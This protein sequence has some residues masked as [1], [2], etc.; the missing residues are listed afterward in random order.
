MKKCNI[1]QHYPLRIPFYKVI[2][3][4]LIHLSYMMILLSV[5]TMLS[6]PISVGNHRIMGDEWINKH[7]DQTI[8]VKQLKVVDQKKYGGRASCGYHALSNA[9]H[10]MEA[11]EDN[12]YE[13]HKNLYDTKK[14]VAQFGK[15]GIWRYAVR[16][17]RAAMGE[18][19]DGDWVEMEEIREIIDTKY[20]GK[21]SI[22]ADP[23]EIS[24]SGESHPYYNIND[25]KAN[26]HTNN[27]V[28]AFILGSMSNGISSTSKWSK[29]DYLNSGHW[30]SA[31]LHIID[32]K[33]CEL[34][35]MDSLG[36][37]EQHTHPAVQQLLR[38][39]FGE[40][41]QIISVAE[42]FDSSKGVDKNKENEKDHNQ[43]HR[44]SYTAILKK[45]LFCV[46]GAIGMYFVAS[47]FLPE[48]S[49]REEY[50]MH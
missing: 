37:K 32:E 40:V 4:I 8:Y 29:K 19:D 35:I 18:W 15:E 21:I 1:L 42:E 10:I 46:V 36:K 16:C 33:T 39:L 50:E 12:T 5:S 22:Y 26:A 14:I 3:T 24:N 48:E 41:T 31:V 44:I 47:S 6:S 27:Y 38:E 17:V 49:D 20:N 7:G 30:I 25:V 34:F 43:S 23:N 9:E 28:H 13:L 2:M 11:L 45:S